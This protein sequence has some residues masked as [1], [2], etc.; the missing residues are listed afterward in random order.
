MKLVISTCTE[1]EAEGLATKLLE[2][3]LVA[4]VNIVNGVISKYWWEGNLETDKESMLFMKTEDSLVNKLI[5]RIKEIH[6]YNVPEI[7]AFDIKGGNLD[8]LNW[9]KAVLGQK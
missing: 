5:E 4:C 7:V 6:S 1:K 9:I 2:E 3:R 8:Y